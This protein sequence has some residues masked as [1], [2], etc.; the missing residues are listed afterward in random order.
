MFFDGASNKKGYGIGI[1]LITQDDSHTPIAIKLDFPYTNNMTEYKACKVG[2]KVSL[3]NGIQCLDVYEDSALIIGQV[4]RKWR[5][6][7]EKLQ[8]FHAHLEELAS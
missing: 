1:L 3:K 5:V 7:D 6:K 4:L 8:P 2:L